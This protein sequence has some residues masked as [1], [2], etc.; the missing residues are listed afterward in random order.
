MSNYTMLINSQ[1]S[2]KKLDPYSS[3]VISQLMIHHYAVINY[4]EIK[5]TFRIQKRDNACYK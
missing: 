1:L 2:F 3:I 4:F 5:H